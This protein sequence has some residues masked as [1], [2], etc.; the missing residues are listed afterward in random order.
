MA[1]DKDKAQLE[2]ASLPIKSGQCYQHYKGEL[3]RVLKLAIKEDSL[4]QLVIYKSLK[5]KT[6][7]ART[8]AN[9]NETVTVDGQLVERF[10]LLDK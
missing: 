3:Y 10:K 2:L 4:E 8:Y 5:K 1:D 6:I 7:W 9:F